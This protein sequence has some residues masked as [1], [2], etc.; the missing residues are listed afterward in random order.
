MEKID[1]RTA[2]FAWV[3][4]GTL[5]K[6]SSL[7]AEQGYT[8]P[9]NGQNWHFTTIRAAANR[10]MLE[11]VEEARKVFLEQGSKL[12]ERQ[13]EAKMVQTACTVYHRIKF[14]DWVGKN[15]WA[16]NYEDI[17]NKRWPGVVKALKEEYGEPELRS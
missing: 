3:Q 1:D 15:L 10:F 13:W 16:L 11:N 9:A 7:M 17:L 12:T 14:I 6:A 4:A 2:F 5:S 8:N